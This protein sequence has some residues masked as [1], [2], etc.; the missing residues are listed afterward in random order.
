MLRA[1]HR[2]ENEEKD[3]GYHEWRH[4]EFFRSVPLSADIDR[5]K[6]EATYRNGILNVTLPKTEQAKGRRIEVKE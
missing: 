2:A 3:R 5:E 4:Q 1:A 6:V